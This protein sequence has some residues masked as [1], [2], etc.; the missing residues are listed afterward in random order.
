MLD[1]SFCWFRRGFIHCI[2]HLR[3][4]CGELYQ[5]KP[6]RRS[7]CKGRK[8]EA[9]AGET[10]PAEEQC[11]SEVWGLPCRPCGRRMRWMNPSKGSGCLWEAPTG[12]GYEL[13]H[14]LQMLDRPQLQARDYISTFEYTQTFCFEWLHQVI[15]HKAN[16][17][18]TI[19]LPFI[20][21]S[22]LFRSII[23]LHFLYTSQC[24]F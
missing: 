7:P 23:N 8:A 20:L 15:G 22:L 18:F 5:G 12:P 19:S 16:I 21:F 9:V 6:W 2:K 24:A 4:F 10:F 3:R 14:S 11:S 13:F 1:E 17:C